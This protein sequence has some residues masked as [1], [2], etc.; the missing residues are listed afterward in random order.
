MR[1][2]EQIIR[3]GLTGNQAGKGGKKQHAP[4][5]MAPKD[6]NVIRITSLQ[7]RRSDFVKLRTSISS[8]THPARRPPDGSRQSSSSSSN[9]SGA[10][11]LSLVSRTGA[12]FSSGRSSSGSSSSSTVP[13]VGG[14]TRLT[15][16]GGSSSNSGFF[17]FHGGD[18]CE[19]SGL[20]CAYIMPRSVRRS[21]DLPGER[22]YTIDCRCCC[23]R[24]WRCWRT[25]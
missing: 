23:P 18:L 5:I 1:F 22:S 9:S 2:R 6:K 14:A 21:G 3:L 11:V 4:R 20:R 13:V 17:Y 16:E 25:S 15:P 24:H 7:L 10:S 8:L 12:S 19:C